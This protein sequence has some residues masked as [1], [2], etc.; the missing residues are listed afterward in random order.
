MS[1]CAPLPHHSAHCGNQGCESGR[2]LLPALGK[3][4]SGLAIDTTSGRRT[5]MLF[6]AIEPRDGTAVRA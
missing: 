6:P 5:V 3:T 1:Q 4:S 2:S